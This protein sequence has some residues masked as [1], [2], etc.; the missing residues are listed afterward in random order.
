MLLA[1]LNCNTVSGIANA[2]VV[3]ELENNPVLNVQPEF[4]E[5]DTVK[6]PIYFLEPHL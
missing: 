6:V 2:T 5:V 3:L 4:T 1:C